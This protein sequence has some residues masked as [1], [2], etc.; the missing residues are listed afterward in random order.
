MRLNHYYENHVRNYLQHV[1]IEFLRNK[2]VL[3]TGV[4]GM[5]GSAMADFLCLAGKNIRVL[6]MG[7]SKER[8]GERFTYPW[9]T[10]KN[11]SVNCKLKLN[12]NII[13]KHY[14]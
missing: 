12:K 5:I 14:Q 8:A 9:F 10:V 6:G 11:F 7:R 3:I 4:T 13:K 2:T 1:D